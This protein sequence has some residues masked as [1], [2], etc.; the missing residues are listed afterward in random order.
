M[1]LKT[2][3]AAGFAAIMMSLFA[4]SPAEAGTKVVIGIGNFGWGVQ[5]CWGGWRYCGRHHRHRNYAYVPRHHNRY[6]VY[7]SDGY[8]GRGY[9]RSHR[10]I[11]CATA[12]RIVGRNGYASVRTND[13]RGDVFTF[14]AR[15]NGKFHRV[16]VNAR[17]G[18]IIGSNRY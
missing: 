13:C 6:V 9:A 11:S 17:N 7:Y 1:A 3:I 4:G 15:K 18:R 16:R 8:G 14:N 5:S 2:T 12:G 10:G